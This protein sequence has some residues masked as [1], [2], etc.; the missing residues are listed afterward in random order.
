MPS[1]SRPDVLLPPRGPHDL[2]D[3]ALLGIPSGLSSIEDAQVGLMKVYMSLLI[4]RS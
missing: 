3:A 2:H 1:V 4:F